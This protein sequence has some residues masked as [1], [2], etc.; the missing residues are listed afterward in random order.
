M[1]DEVR[2]LVLSVSIG[3]LAGVVMH[4]AILAVDPKAT[5][6]GGEPG[7]PCGCQNDVLCR[8]P[9]IDCCETI[10]CPIEGCAK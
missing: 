2:A 7:K 4:Q 10:P 3:A 6:C 1:R 5:S 9:C 8:E